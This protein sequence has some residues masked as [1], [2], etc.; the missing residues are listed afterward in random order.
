VSATKLIVV[1]RAALAG[2]AKVT[3]VAKDTLAG[4]TKGS[5]LDPAQ[6]GVVFNLSYGNGATAGSFTLPAGE[7]DGTSGWLTNRSTVAKFVNRGAPAGPT[8][9]KLAIV[10][11]GKLLKLVGKSLGDSPIDVMG[12]G[13]PGA[14]GV[15]TEFAITNGGPTFRHCSEWTGCEYK[16]IG[17]ETG[18]KLVCRDGLPIACP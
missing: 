14:S 17:A 12:A 16:L 8:S 11:P 13:D 7:S 18:V 1:D 6:I 2:S 3:F 4:I 15:R 5:G 10:K 9:A